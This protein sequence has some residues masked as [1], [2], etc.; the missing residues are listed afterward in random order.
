MKNF[1]RT[2][3]VLLVFAVLIAFI[4]LNNTS[5]FSK[6]GDTENLLLAH[7]GVAQ[8]F[9]MEGIEWDTCTAERI[10]KPEHPFLENTIQSI[11]AAFEAGA[12]VVEFDIKRTKD[13]QLAVFHDG[14]LECRTNV[15]GEPSDYTMEE[16]RQLDIGYGYTADGGKTFPFRFK[17][18][19]LMPSMDEVLSKFP[20]KNLLIHIKSSNPEDGK[21]LIEYLKKMPKEQLGFL[22]VYGDD[23][24][25]AV[26][27]E[28]LPEL[29]VMSIATLKSCLLPYI[30]VGWTGFVPSAC[31]NTQLHIPEKYAP[32]FW[33]FPNKFVERM[34]KANTRVILVAGDGGWSEGFD[35]E[36]DLERLPEGYRGGIWTNSIERIAPNL[37]KKN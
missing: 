3:K 22:T 21:L 31:K 16:L 29:R 6:K 5:L 18:I 35:T 26:I 4:F 12:D 15:S 1:T 7:R 17:G 24:P 9:S 33:G 28:K 14:T 34:E 19:G 8:T 32:F 25:I 37:E 30:G 27:Q 2:K 11:E 36:Q 13:N 10:Y 20:N 23:E